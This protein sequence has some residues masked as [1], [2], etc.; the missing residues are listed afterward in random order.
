MEILPRTKRGIVILDLA[1]RIDADSANFIETVGQCLRDGYCDIL[2]NFEA[3]DF[4]DYMG[5][6][7]IF[8]AYKEVVNCKGRMKFLNVP[9]H[10][11]E[12]FAVAGLD[13]VV[14]IYA[15]E[16]LALN[17]FKEDRVIENI[18]KM[19]LRRRFK[20]L[21]L[22][23]K[24]EL[25][26]KQDSGPI[27]LKVDLL[28]LS[29]VGAYLFGCDKFKLGDR[30]VLKIDLPSERK[31]FLLNAKVV[32]LSDKDIQHHIHP[33]MGV[34]FCNIPSSVQDELVKFIEKN[35]SLA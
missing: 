15:K 25:L 29:G 7:A 1:G 21:P 35:L 34:E 31:T 33:G 9:V 28:D 20:R 18:Q 24:I 23:I 5:V 26:S 2:C 3:V 17:A 12:L 30:V 19:Q 13:R 8:I 14:E 22:D 6:S 4:I 27:C 16:E 32:W 11:R 10:V